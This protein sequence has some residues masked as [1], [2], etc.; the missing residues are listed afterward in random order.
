MSDL[1]GWQSGARQAAFDNQ[2]LTEGN[3]KIQSDQMSLEGQRLDLDSRRKMLSML[4]GM[5]QS[6]QQ[7]GAAS[8]LGGQPQSIPDVM[9]QLS[10]IALASG[11][12][13][14]AKDYAV[15][16]STIRNNQATADHQLLQNEIRM[17]DTIG[18]L[19]D[20][21]HDQKSWD[22]AKLVFELLHPD[23]AAK[24]EFQ[25]IKG[26]PYIPQVVDQLRDG[27]ATQK[28]KLINNLNK[29]KT[30]SARAEAEERRHRVGLIDAQRDAAKARATALDKVGGGS[31]KSADVSLIT[32]LIAADYGDD[33]AKSGDAKF[34]ASV[35]AE[36][37]VQMMRKEHLSRTEA[38][39]RAYEQAKQRG[40]LGGFRSSTN[41]PGSSARNPMK[42]DSTAKLED[43]LYY[44]PT[45][46]KYAGKT[47]LYMN[48]KLYE[49][50]AEH[51]EADDEEDDD[52]T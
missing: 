5:G 43:G 45:Q 31:V 29:A 32:D 36:D 48:G 18:G 35:I 39:K 52:G 30:E 40:D 16:G 2:A 22:Q 28:E 41:L 38:A 24:P 1:W 7:G 6:P 44:Q 37:A 11:L 51:I 47:F 27:M 50:D 34:R 14:K 4:S 8:P 13:E 21:V 10:K 25:Q 33:R 19:M 12:P 17:A 49:A 23:L 15:A 9:D 46:G 42:T 26:L 20:N 3:L